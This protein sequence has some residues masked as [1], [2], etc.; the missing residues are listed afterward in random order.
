MPLETPPADSTAR[1]ANTHSTTVLARMEAHSPLAKPRLNRPLPISR[2]ASA[3]WFQV[4]LR[5]R[6]RCFCRIQMLGPRLATA[7]QNMAGMVSPG[8]TM[9]WQGFIEEVSQSPLLGYR[10]FFFFFQ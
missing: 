4:Q 9:S 5:H 7:F 2:T 10:Q 8:M 6:P 3:V 1:S